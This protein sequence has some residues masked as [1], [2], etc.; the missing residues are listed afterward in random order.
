[1]LL[2]T[3]TPDD[4]G[5]ASTAGV[6]GFGYEGTCQGGGGGAGIAAGGGGAGGEGEDGIV[7]TDGGGG[8]GG[9]SFAAASDVTSGFPPWADEWLTQADQ[10]QGLVSLFFFESGSGPPPAPDD[11]A[12]I[13]D[14]Q[15]TLSFDGD[16]ESFSYLISEVG[17]G[18]TT[19]GSRLTGNTRWTM[20][21]D[22]ALTPGAT[23]S[24]EVVDSSGASV[25]DAR[26]F[27]VDAD[28]TA[29][30]QGVTM[31]MR[32]MNYFATTQ[33]DAPAY[34]IP[35]SGQAVPTST[36]T[37]ATPSCGPDGSNTCYQWTAT[38]DNP[39]D[40]DTYFTTETAVQATTNPDAINVDWVTSDPFGLGLSELFTLHVTGVLTVP[41]SGEYTFGVNAYGGA[42]F[43][44]TDPDGSVVGD[45]PMIDTWGQI[46][47]CT[48]EG[49]ENGDQPTVKE[50][51]PWQNSALANAE[52]L[53]T[54]AQGVTTGDPV[55]L[56]A[57][58]PYS[59]EVD[60]FMSWLP[61]PF[62][63][64]YSSA[65]LVSDLAPIPGSWLTCP[66][67]TVVA[68]PEPPA[69]ASNGADDLDA[70]SRST[71]L[72]NEPPRTV[73]STDG[74]RSA[75]APG[76][77]C[78]VTEP[79]PQLF[80]AAACAGLD[81]TFTAQI[82]SE[83]R[84][85]SRS[86]AVD[87]A[88]GTVPST[89]VAEAVHGD[90]VVWSFTP[91]VPTAACSDSPDERVVVIEAIDPAAEVIDGLGPIQVGLASGSA[92]L[93]VGPPQAELMYRSPGGV[94][95]ESPGGSDAL[96][97]GWSLSGSATGIVL[98]ADGRC[99]GVPPPV[100]GSD[101]YLA[102]NGLVCAWS[103]PQGATTNVWY[104]QVGADDYQ[105]G[106][107]VEPGGANTQ[108][109]WASDG[110]QSWPQLTGV[111]TQPEIDAQR[112]TAMSESDAVWHV[113]YN[114]VGD[115]TSIV[116]PRPAFAA[117]TAGGSREAI[118]FTYDVDGDGRQVTTIFDATVDNP[119]D[120]TGVIPGMPLAARRYSASWRPVP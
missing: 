119:D 18:T 79:A 39:D 64:L 50:Q 11:G 46:E 8:G 94:G 108:V 47:T 68:D 44:L 91:D 116:S 66:D 30:T 19:V 90:V 82:G 49:P 6:G 15:P 78:V 67:C 65:A 99:D 74:C 80:A 45:A 114:A 54:N 88:P 89:V 87:T 120:P 43:T 3:E 59:L 62:Q 97:D 52:G 10:T 92:R 23:Y 75:D 27:T 37:V 72:L 101:V 35:E 20:P 103:D 85:I 56:E 115:V 81:G 4:D 38:L 48:Y 107:I 96:P 84:E 109:F 63:L 83:I 118:A 25:Q 93:A 42:R 117:L 28:A 58:T 76:L 71:G 22:S 70:V 2:A 111:Q 105:I 61:G 1:S 112:R 9:A 41:F 36:V 40:Y 60:G 34:L 21:T 86:Y 57:G 12:T 24:W 73:G 14:T 104:V 77:G 26:T 29:G 17:S 53:C 102:P 7:G 98:G 13:V 51:T 31:E 113:N 106:W 32:S 5:N 110:G 16:T 95:Y 33:T 69:L 55:T 100:D